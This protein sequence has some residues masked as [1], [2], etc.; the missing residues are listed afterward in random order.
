[1]QLNFKVR[2]S[3][4][5]ENAISGLIQENDITAKQLEFIY[6]LKQIWNDNEFLW[7]SIS[8]KSGQAQQNYRILS[9][10]TAYQFMKALPFLS[11]IAL[12]EDFIF[13][14]YS[15]WYENPSIHCQYRFRVFLYYLRELMEISMQYGE[16]SH[17]WLQNHKDWYDH[18]E[19]VPDQFGY[20]DHFYLEIFQK[21]EDE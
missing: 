7:T 5:Q 20:D 19:F 8:L 13:S 10:Q 2:R 11:D 9:W 3:R 16:N 14:I 12:V 4:A 15:I 1:M 6:R 21:Y 18:L 17:T